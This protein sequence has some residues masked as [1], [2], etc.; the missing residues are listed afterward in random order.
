MA[1]RPRMAQQKDIQKRK[2]ELASQID[3]LRSTM[4]EDRSELVK[5]LNPIQRISSGLQRHPL[6]IFSVTFVLTAL[7]TILFRRKPKPAKTEK[8]KAVTRGFLTSTL[9]G[10][11]QPFIKKLLIQFL[12][13]KYGDRFSPISRDSLLGP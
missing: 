2:R 4:G 6:R 1:K 9:L 5:R 3:T 13:Y 12:Q 10:I 7:A 8:K 11:A